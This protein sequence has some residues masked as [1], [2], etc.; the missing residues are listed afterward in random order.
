MGHT[1]IQGGWVWM[2][3]GG[4]LAPHCPQPPQPPPLLTDCSGG[5]GLSQCNP[6]PFPG[7]ARW[8][9]AL[10]KDLNSI[11]FIEV[12]LFP[13]NQCIKLSLY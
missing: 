3:S 11:C 4:M 5:P 6:N 10:P 8:E 9:P 12:S 13:P 1:W 2:G 7:L